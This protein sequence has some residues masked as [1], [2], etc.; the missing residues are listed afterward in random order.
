MKSLIV[1]PQSQ[2]LTGIVDVPGDKSI[3]HRALI[4]AALA[5]GTTTIRGLATSEDVANTRKVLVALGTKIKIDGELVTVTGRGG[6][7][8]KAE[9]ILYCGN[10]GTTMR[11]MLGVLAGQPFKSCL[12]GDASLNRR[13][14]DRVIEPLAKMGAKFSVKTDKKWGRMIE[15]VGCRPLDSISYVLPVASAQ[16]K[17]AI[18]LADLFATGVSQIGEPSPSRDH[19]ERMLPMWGCQPGSKKLTAPRQPV[20]IPGDISSAAFFVAAASLIAGSDVQ[21]ADVGVNPSRTGILDVMKRWKGEVTWNTSDAHDEP[22]SNLKIR[23]SR[24]QGEELNIEGDLIPRLID[25]I[26]VI[27]MLGAFAGGILRVRDA[28]E[29]RVKESDRIETLAQELRRMGALVTT[30]PD[31]FD[32]E[33]G[34]SLKPATFESHGDHRI[35]MTFAVAGLALK[36]GPTTVHNTDCIATSFPEFVS[37]LRK[38]RAD[39]QEVTH[40]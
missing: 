36:G 24:L 2:P 30:S 15:V 29:L 25:E 37:T 33:G 20:K 34:G 21:I 13:P 1:Q 14:M 12:T 26:P 3:S 11:L 6:S 10:S 9:D 19:T 38:L 23:S 39:I 28:K 4:F 8:D 27:G 18:L 22:M 32:V 16:V 35:A 17:S 40:V 7:F 5:E 31:G